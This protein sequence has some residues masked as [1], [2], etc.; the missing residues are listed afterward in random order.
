MYDVSIHAIVTCYA[1][2]GR[3]LTSPQLPGLFWDLP[4]GPVDRDYVAM[5][6]REAGAPHDYQM[7]LHTQVYSTYQEREWLVRC[8]EP[9]GHR[10]GTL[11]TLES[12]IKATPRPID[13]STKS[14]TGEA[15]FAVV[16]PSDTVGWV[17]DQMFPGDS[18]SLALLEPDGLSILNVSHAPDDAPNRLDRSVTIAQ[19]FEMRPTI[20]RVSAD[21]ELHDR[22]DLEN[23][24]RREREFV[25]L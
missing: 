8:A 1:G 13:Q 25:L 14:D 15:T 18:I 2:F 5:V 7:H 21:F 20:V 23:D 16:L 6:L 19:L 4:E 12:L 3:S 17:A 11:R 24:A 22:A 10:M 9:A